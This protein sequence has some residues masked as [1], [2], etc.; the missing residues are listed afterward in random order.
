M[1]PDVNDII[2][3]VARF[4]RVGGGDVYTNTLHFKVVTASWATNLIFM[5]EMADFLDDTYT[6]VNGEISSAM[7][8]SDIDGQNLT[9]DVLLPLV[10]WPVLT[11]GGNVSEQLPTQVTARPYWPTTRPKTRAALG[12]IPFGET[13][14]AAGGLLDA[15]AI[16][17]IEDFADELVGTVTLVSGTLLYGAYNPEFTRFTPVDSRVVPSRFRTLRR[18]RVGVGT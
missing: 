1:F 2:R 13:S 10:T 17:A 14:Q 8:Y 11:I 12:L 4:Q 6:F 9:Q 18:R 15:T 5:G 3:M 7:E 16:G